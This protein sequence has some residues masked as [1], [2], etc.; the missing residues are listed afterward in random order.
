[1]YSRDN[2]LK[3]LREAVLEVQ[4]KKVDGTSRT[5]RC[6]LKPDMLPPSYV[7]EAEQE[8]KFHKENE[9]VVAV[10]DVTKGGWRSFRMDSIEYIQDV[11]GGY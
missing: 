8:K 6:T 10:W 7:T 5:M 9:N 4:F 11:S 1:M 3:D 2:V